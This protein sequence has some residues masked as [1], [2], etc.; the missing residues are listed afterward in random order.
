MRTHTVKVAG[1]VII[2]RQKYG[3]FHQPSVVLDHI[4]YV[5]GVILLGG[6]EDECMKKSGDGMPSMP[7]VQGTGR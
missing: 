5:D 6:V 2:R 7:G 3:S 1:R 4:L